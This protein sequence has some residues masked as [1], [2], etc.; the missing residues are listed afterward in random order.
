MR[1][2]VEP[3]VVL[4]V[5]DDPGVR[6][7]DAPTLVMLHGF[8]GSPLDFEDHIEALT[9]T[10]RVVRFFQRGHG[11]SGRPIEPE[12]YTLDRL[13][14]DV[15][16]VVDALTLDV[17]TLFGWSMGGMVARRV[18]LGAPERVDRLIL[19]DTTPGPVPGYER[20]LVD[21][22]A[23]VARNEGMRALKALL[24][25]V[26]PL[27]TPAYDALVASRPGYREY[28]DG[29]FWT[30]TPEAFAGLAEELASQP[31][32]TDRLRTV[33]V[34]TL[35]IVGSLDTAFIPGCESIAGAI[36]GARLAVIEDAGHAPQFE[37]P[38]AWRS[39]MVDFLASQAD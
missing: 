32:E 35:V 18:V 24:D 31:D 11:P 7:A 9:Q 38:D 17:F 1:V 33:A 15:L 10:H 30:M 16:A 20:S 6:G 39:V 22:G 21:I 25:S 13:A 5:F 36:P 12:A 14:A 27:T 19:Q 29:R 2:E 8:G 34:P 4:E 26:Q 3:G 37:M 28:V 23:A